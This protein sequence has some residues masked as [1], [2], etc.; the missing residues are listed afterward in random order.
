[1]TLAIPTGIFEHVSPFNLLLIIRS[2]KMVGSRIFSPNRKDSQR[3]TL[4]NVPS[5]A[6]GFNEA[7]CILVQS[8]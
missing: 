6:M 8:M 1:M 5:E 2:I 3:R 7:K 4:V